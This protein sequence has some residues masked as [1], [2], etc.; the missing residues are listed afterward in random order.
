MIRK[1]LSVLKLNI[2]KNTSDLPN[3]LAETS[4]IP[5]ASAEGWYLP[6]TA[7]ILLDTPLR[8]QYLKTIWQNVSMSPEMFKKLY[9]EPIN[10]YSEMVQLLPASES[11]H[12]AHAGGMLDHGL[13]VIAIATKLRQNYVLPQNAAPEEQ[14]RQ[15]DVWTAVIIYA[16]LLHDIGKVAADIEIQLKN[17]TRWFP[18][19]GI[20]KEAYKFRYI[21]ERDYNLHPVLG[22]LLAQYLLPEAAL[23]WIA[24]FNQAFTAFNYFIAGHTDKAGILSEIIQKADQIS[25]TMALGGDPAKLAEKPQISFAKQLHIALCHVIQNFKLNAPK[26][27]CDGWLT[28]DG[29]WLMSKSTADNIRA[30]LMSQGVSVPSQN[31]KLFDELQSYNLIEKTEQG[32]AIWNGRPISN[33]GWAPAKPFTLLK[34]SPGIIW[35]NIE[36]RPSLFDGR[37]ELE[38]SLSA[39]KLGE[40]TVIQNPEPVS[41]EIV[42]VPETYKKD[43]ALDFVLGLFPVNESIESDSNTEIE[44]CIQEKRAVSDKPKKKEKDKMQLT[45]DS[46]DII[47]GERF[48]LWLKAGIISGKLSYNRP[49]AKVHLVKNHL[50]LV[51]PSI[52]QLYLGEAGITDKNPGSSCR[53]VSRI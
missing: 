23:N 17:D 28:N 5:P 36:Q 45:G 21:K 31:G 26:G 4:S 52:F 9:Q 53:N 51:T 35:G 37:L 8:Q 39:I 29:L 44:N 3:I 6:Q 30:Y 22:S 34:V 16:A 33:M 2:F 48:L 43:A 24:P 49:N 27:G 11:H 25:V 32:M 50:F 15:R 47:N 7:K 14:A 1:F 46:R 38:D 19:Q 12:H 18:W 10:R 20:P 42:G 40:S 41:G 13:E